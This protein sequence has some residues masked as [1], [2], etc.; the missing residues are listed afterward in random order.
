MGDVDATSSALDKILSDTD[1]ATKMGLRAKA[2][3]AERWNWD[4]YAR[5]IEHVYE[6]VIG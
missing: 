6:R 2:D 5:E 3:I 4:C 1:Q